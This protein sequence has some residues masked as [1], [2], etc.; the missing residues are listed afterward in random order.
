M[1]PASEA[2]WSKSSTNR[3]AESWPLDWIRPAWLVDLSTRVDFHY[4]YI[5]KILSSAQA[6]AAGRSCLR[7]LAACDIRPSAGGFNNKKGGR[8]LIYSQIH[9]KPTSWNI[10]FT[11]TQGGKIVK[12]EGERAKN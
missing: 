10:Y 4:I 6:S 1:R 11:T 7:K 5:V 8:D 3:P 9:L 2:S 12:I